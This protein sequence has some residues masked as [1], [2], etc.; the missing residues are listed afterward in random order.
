M[1]VWTDSDKNLQ[2]EFGKEWEE[3]LAEGTLK[4]IQKQAQEMIDVSTTRN[5]GKGK[6]KD[7]GV[8]EKANKGTKGKKSIEM[9]MA[10]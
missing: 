6:N 2:F 9:P 10:F 4:D 3:Y 8:K 1:A 5:K 7:G